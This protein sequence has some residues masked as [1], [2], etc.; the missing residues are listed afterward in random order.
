[1]KTIFIFCFFILLHGMMKAQMN[2]SF[3]DG[4]FSSNP[5]WSGDIQ[6]FKVNTAF[7]LQLNSGGEGQS[8]L[9]TPVSPA[10][11]M[12][13]SFWVKLGFSPSEN[14]WRKYFCYRISKTWKVS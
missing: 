2:D 7:Q 6:Q 8:S 11:S 13:W 4:D 5:A 10:D 9:V 14:N 1:M 3:T 12:E